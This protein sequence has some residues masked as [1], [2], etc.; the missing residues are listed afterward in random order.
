M[1]G[2][3]IVAHGGLAEELRRAMEH[4]VG[5]QE[6]VRAIGIQPQGDLRDMQAA[7]NAAVDAVDQGDGVILVTDMFGGTP[8]NLAMGAMRDSGV[9]VIYG[10]NLP[11]LIKLAKSRAMPM[12]EATACALSAGRKYVDSAT[13]ILS[14]R[15]KRTA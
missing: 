11:L 8:S 1:I 14:A 6:G 5:P 2:L 3:V 9:E 4:V 7:V 12:A 15:R 10:A 13:S